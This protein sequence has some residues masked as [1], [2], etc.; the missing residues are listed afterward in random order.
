LVIFLPYQRRKYDRKMLHIPVNE[1]I[2]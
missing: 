2:T 1:V